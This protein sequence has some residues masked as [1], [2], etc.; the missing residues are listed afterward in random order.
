MGSQKRGRYVSS[1]FDD[2]RV[3]LL[4]QPIREGRLA[5]LARQAVDPVD[6]AAVGGLRDEVDSLLLPRPPL[7]LLPYM[8]QARGARGDA[9]RISAQ[10]CRKET[11]ACA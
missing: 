4:D 2:E 6:R 3:A 7:E 11:C 8:R 9:T 10:G 5:E 1:D